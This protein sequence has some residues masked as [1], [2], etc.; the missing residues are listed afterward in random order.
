MKNLLRSQTMNQKKPHVCP[1][2]LSGTLDSKLRKLFQNP[3]KILKPYIREGITALEIGCGPGFFTLDMAKMVGQSGKVI[4]ADVQQGM[5]EKVKSKIKDTQ[6]EQ[7]ITL[8]KCDEISLGIFEPVDFVLLFY[9]VHEVPDTLKLFSQLA[10][11]LKPTGQ[12]L[13]T[14]PSFHVSAKKF[15]HMLQLAKDQGFTD[16]QGPRI[17][18]S[19]TAI[20]KKQNHSLPA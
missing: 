6:F 14:E 8:H 12:I 10:S 7:Q 19:K 5:L 15:Q 13:I 18:L 1:V 16:L 17:L 9:V 2:G 20:L 3:K 4:A 11:L